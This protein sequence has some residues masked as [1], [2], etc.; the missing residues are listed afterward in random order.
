M[1]I[2]ERFRLIESNLQ[3]RRFIPN[4][5]E[6]IKLEKA[7]KYWDNLNR[8]NVE[9]YVPNAIL[10]QLELYTIDKRL[11]ENPKKKYDLINKLLE[12]YGLKPLSAGTNRKVFYHKDD[13]FIVFKLGLDSI[14]KNDNLNE[15]HMQKLL[16]PFFAKMFST[17]YNGLLSISERVETM[18]EIDYKVHWKSDIFN[19]IISLLSKGYVMEDI[20]SNFF[21]NWGVRIGFGP[22]MLDCPYIYKVDIKKLRCTH[23]DPF[24]KKECGG[25]IDYNYDKGMSEI[26]CM[27]CGTRYFASQLAQMYPVVPIVEKGVY[28]MGY[29]NNNFQ[30]A[31]IDT[32][33][34]KTVHKYFNETDGIVT[35]ENLGPRRVAIN[36]Y[37]DTSGIVKPEKKNDEVEIEGFKMDKE[38]FETMKNYFLQFNL[39]IETVESSDFLT[40][41]FSSGLEG[42]FIQFIDDN[43]KK[44]NTSTPYEVILNFIY[45]LCD[46]IGFNKDRYHRT[47]I[48]RTQVPIKTNTSVNVQQQ[49]QQNNTT[50]NIAELADYTTYYK[51]NVKYTKYPKEVKTE[52]IYWLKRIEKNFGKEAAIFLASKLEVKFIPT[53]DPQLTPPPPIPN[54]NKTVKQVTLNIPTKRTVENAQTQPKDNLFP[55]EP[56]N[57]DELNN[58]AYKGIDTKD[59][60]MGFAGESL[61]KYM[62][63]KASIPML[64]EKIIKNFDNVVLQ[65][66]VNKQ[67]AELKA[68]ILTFIYPDLLKAI[69]STDGK[70]IDLV[71]ER[72]LDSRNRDSFKLK[73]F[74]YSSPL[75]ETNLSIKDN[76]E[77]K[78]L[79]NIQ[80]FI[81]SEK[82]LGEFLSEE[83]G[84]IDLSCITDTNEAKVILINRLFAVLLEKT[85]HMI[86]PVDIRNIVTN[87]VNYQIQFKNNSSQT[88]ETVEDNL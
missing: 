59:A 15:F 40:Y 37:E 41:F 16:K 67:M 84:K 82:E 22:V 76:K 34:H 83:S 27:K 49:V 5:E 12:P 54:N 28:K 74:D 66:D 3:L 62:R 17:T 85:K 10:N 53:T 61:T 30:V 57:Q 21:K 72:T 8:P 39:N 19:T 88:P 31:V 6:K 86:N 51:D 55:V 56:K 14:G 25:Y 2:K 13:P 60:V 73:F 58:N 71:I 32:K 23:K 44:G 68:K 1:D 64:Q 79:E 80:A 9:Y 33:N 50:E 24:T 36:E 20:G 42:S 4:L 29:F 65:D 63:L 26:S 35:S 78:E 87:Y 7:I 70:G 69:N 47:V 52:I 81:N 38:V 11:R 43:K 48:N 46:K 75:F 45:Y 18:S 77:T